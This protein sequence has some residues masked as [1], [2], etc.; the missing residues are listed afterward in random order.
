MER[1]IFGKEITNIVDQE[2]NKNRRNYSFL[3][4]DRLHAQ[5][6]PHKVTRPNKTQPSQS[7][8][9]PSLDSNPQ[10]VP[11]YFNEI[12]TFLREQE[13]SGRKSQ[14]YVPHHKNVSEQT[15]AKLI[16]WLGELHQKYK[17]FPETIFTMVELV[18]RYL[19]ARDT[20]LSE[21]QLVGV[22][23]LFIA[24]K[25]EETYQVPQLKQLAACCAHQYTPE[26]ILEKE[27]DM[28]RERNF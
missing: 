6:Q 27:A 16:D 24:A 7:T 22:S 2:A 26:Q 4:A 21:L 28:I 25:F 23:A 18:D 13:R 3:H 10:I 5:P 17:M 11:E 1:R 9:T 20:P 19:A 15:R 14:N 12:M 8:S